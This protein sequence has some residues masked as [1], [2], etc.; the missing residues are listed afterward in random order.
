MKI[1]LFSFRS[2]T[3]K[4]SCLIFCASFVIYSVISMTKS[5]YAA[6]IASIIGEGL[7]NKSQAGTINAGFYL[8][9]GAAQLL[10]AKYVDKISPVSL[11]YT[12]LAGTLFSTIG[13]SVSN[14]FYMMLIFWSFCGLIQF[15]IW[16]AVLRIISEYLLPEHKTQAMTYISFSYCVGMLIN[17]LAASVVLSVARWN[18]LFVLFSVILVFCLVLWKWVIKSTKEEVNEIIKIN[19]NLI[20]RALKEK[21]QKHG[22]LKENIKLLKLLISSGVIFLLIP[23]LI[24]TALDAGLKSWV[25]TM[26]VENYPVSESF[27]SMLTTI[28]VFVNLSGVVLVNYFYPKYIK[29]ECLGYALCFLVA[30]P[31][32]ALLLLTGKVPVFVVVALL[33]VVTT[34]MYAGHQLVNVII[35][36]RFAKYNKTGA[37]A[38]TLNA[39]ASFGAVIANIAF[40]ALAEHGWSGTILSWSIL[41]LT[42]FVF[43]LIAT[44][45]WKNF[46]SKE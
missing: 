38:S 42:A 7:F 20:A 29:N 6:S 37:V 36:S 16:P 8:F 17:Y 23:T 3:E 10:G 22:A 34:M 44:L 43:C 19:Q 18:L 31:F 26:I 33:C 30:L 11:I 41:A 14:N 9:Y 13:M 15:A 12:A 4:A 27:A 25:P 5:A 28:L 46:K 45:I 39:V 2:H 21:E 35:P 1:R 24:R 40:G 32:T